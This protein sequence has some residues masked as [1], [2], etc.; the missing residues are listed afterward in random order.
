MVKNQPANAG[1]T[2]DSFSIPGSGRSPG[3]GNGNPLK[4]SF[5][6]NP[7]DR[8][9]WQTT[10]RGTKCNHVCLCKREVERDLTTYGRREGNV[11][12]KAEIGVM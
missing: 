12:S 10:V 6:D 1:D 5:Q 3:A 2:R 4:Y 8:G 11:T 9:T 7:M